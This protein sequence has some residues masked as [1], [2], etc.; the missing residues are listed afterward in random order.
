MQLNLGQSGFLL[1]VI[2]SSHSRITYVFYFFFPCN[3]MF[4][5]VSQNFFH[6]LYFLFIPLYGMHLYVFSALKL[7]L[8]TNLLE[9]QTKVN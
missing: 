9:D 2:N 6:I 1:V 3:L 4:N 8:E 7:K 5:C